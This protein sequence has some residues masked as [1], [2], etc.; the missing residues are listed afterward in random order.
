[1]LKGK[2]KEDFEKWV[3]RADKGGIGDFSNCVEMC[4]NYPTDNWNISFTDYPKSMQYG[5]L[6][7]WFDSVGINISIEPYWCVCKITAEI[8]QEVTF[9]MMVFSD[10]QCDYDY[11]NHA[12]RPQARQKAI[13]QAIEIYNNK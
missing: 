9:D 13:E 6:V 10:S 2:A 7:D 5:V 3:G 11:S 8:D 4:E 1:M 12:T